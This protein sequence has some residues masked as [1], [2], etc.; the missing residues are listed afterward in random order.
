MSYDFTEETEIFLFQFDFPHNL[1]SSWY[2]K[3]FHQ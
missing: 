2:I 3:S 1:V